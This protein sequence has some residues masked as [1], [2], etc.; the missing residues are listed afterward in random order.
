MKFRCPEYF[1][2]KRIYHQ[3]YVD[4]SRACLQCPHSEWFECNNYDYTNDQFQPKFSLL[5]SLTISRCRHAEGRWRWVVKHYIGQLCSPH[6]D[7]GTLRNSHFQ[8]LSTFSHLSL[9]SSLFSRKMVY[10]KIWENWKNVR[11]I[12]EKLE[13]DVKTFSSKFIVAAVIH[14]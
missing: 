5:L 2:V 12:Y 7:A 8:V 4:W 13:E 1:N 11:K 3:I 6:L 9:N 14:E 10:G